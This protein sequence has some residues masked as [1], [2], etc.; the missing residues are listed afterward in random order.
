MRQRPKAKGCV[1]RDNYFTGRKP[2]E[3][4]RIEIYHPPCPHVGIS[5]EPTA[6][7][8]DRIASHIMDGYIA[9]RLIVLQSSTGTCKEIS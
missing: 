2:T 4:L 7:Q 1:V 5:S 9:G 6:D 3:Y 8:A